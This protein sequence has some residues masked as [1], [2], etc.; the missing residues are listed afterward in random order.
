MLREDGT[1]YIVA[2]QAKRVRYQEYPRVQGGRSDV[3]DNAGIAW[4]LGQER[5]SK[6][7]FPSE[8]LAALVDGHNVVDD[9]K[10][11]PSDRS[12]VKRQTESVTAGQTGRMRC[13][14]QM[15]LPLAER[16][17]RPTC[18]ILRGPTAAKMTNGAG[19]QGG[20][21]PSSNALKYSVCRSQ[22]S[23]QRSS[24]AAQQR[25]S[26]AVQQCVRQV[27]IRGS[28][29]PLTTEWPHLAIRHSVIRPI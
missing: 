25:S 3:R 21:Q 12:E 4:V 19:K 6:D 2:G 13:R 27:Q 8:A 29:L 16:D 1:P 9:G 5:G 23:V 15:G 7:G 20:S 11:R 22:I 10:Q 14:V 17:R 28:Y 18:A 26:A 24:A